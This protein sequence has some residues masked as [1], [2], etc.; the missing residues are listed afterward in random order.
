MSNAALE[1]TVLDGAVRRAAGRVDKLRA[2]LSAGT[3]NSRDEARA[4]DPWEG[5]R[6]ASVQS[7]YRALLELEP[8]RL[9]APLR[10]GLLRWVH[11]LLQSRL[12]QEL[13]IADA[14]AENALDSRLSRARAALLTAQASKAELGAT[15]AHDTHGGI[16]ARPNTYR[17]ALA[18]AIAAP[19]DAR[20]SAALTLA[21]ELAAPIAAVRKERRE[22]RF[23][24]A[25]RL[26]LAHPFELTSKCNV[27]KLASALLDATEPLAIEIFKDARKRSED[28]WR[29]A[30]AVQLAI[31]RRARDGWPSHLGQRWLDGAFKVL[32][33]RG[34][35]VGPL[36][37]PLGSAT[38]LRAVMAW[39]FAWKTAGTPRSM[40]FA[41]A[42][43]PYP[44]PAFRFGFALASVVAEPSFQSRVLDLP[45]RLAVSQGRVLRTTMLLHART[46]AVRT[47]LASEERVEG[48]R[49][50]ELGVRLFGAPLPSSMR[51]AWPDP[52][53]AEAA[54]LL[55]LLGTHAFVRSLVD[56]FDD[57]WF[58]NPKAGA[59]L[60]SMA[61][62]PAFDVEPLDETAPA[63]L[64]RAFEEALG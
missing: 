38:F 52:R 8:S 32:G 34:V 11:E 4:F 60:T 35:S 23:E 39:G 20:A 48:A 41:I 45:S 13:A 16:D 28:S 30:S 36:P 40:P 24:V 25:R 42:H 26:G 61:C 54:R 43:D 18:A 10:A 37:E 51:D 5:V 59:H 9:D 12:D 2:L 1:L 47:L 55:G 63:V 46:L 62:G 17:E 21:G 14:D 22:R 56:R 33:P 27:A 15:T 29:A 6:H 7:T 58:R 64:A 50:E 49:F 44:V 3:R 57:D 53:P 31:G 19:N